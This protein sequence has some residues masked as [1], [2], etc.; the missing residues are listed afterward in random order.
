MKTQFRFHDFRDALCLFRPKRKK[1]C[2]LHYAHCP[3]K[4]KRTLGS[5]M[6]KANLVVSKAR[7]ELFKELLA[8]SLSASS[9]LRGIAHHLTLSRAA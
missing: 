8:A 3:S 1:W 4:Q 9:A 6:S 2:V 7:K 5:T